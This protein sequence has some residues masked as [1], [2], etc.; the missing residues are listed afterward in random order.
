MRQ[1]ESI[2][3]KETYFDDDEDDDVLLMASQCAEDDDVLMM[4]SQCAEEEDRRRQLE[5]TVTEFNPPSSGTST[6][7]PVYIDKRKELPQIKESELSQNSQKENF[8][9]S[10]RDLMKKHNDMKELLAR[11]DRLTTTNKELRENLLL[12]EGEAKNL[13]LSK[14]AAEDKLTKMRHEKLESANLSRIDPEKD[15]L[16]REVAKLK[17]ERDFSKLDDFKQKISSTLQQPPV[18]IRE[19]SSPLSNTKFFTNFSM[20]SQSMPEVLPMMFEAEESLPVPPESL[21]DSLERDSTEDVVK[22]QLKLAQI[23]TRIIAGGKFSDALIDEIFTDAVFMIFRID[24][25]IKYLEIEEESLYTFDS[26]PA[27]SAAAAISIPELREKLTKV[28]LSNE[29]IFG[30]GGKI[31]IFQAE[32]FFPEE[33]CAKPRR[34]IAFYA[35]L[36]KNSRKFSEKLLIDNVVDDENHR[37]FVSVLTDTLLSRVSQSKNVYDYYGL[38]MAVG[39]L[40]SSLGSHYSKYSNNQIIDIALVKLLRAVLHCRCDNPILMVHVAQFVADT[41]LEPSIISQL[42]VNFPTSEITEISRTYR[43]FKY[44]HGACTFQLFLSYLLTTFKSKNNLNSFELELLME[45]LLNLNKIKSNVQEVSLGI[46][47]FLN[48][49]QANMCGCLQQL[50]NTTL[51]LNYHLLANQ[52]CAFMQSIPAREISNISTSIDEQKFHKR[53][54]SLKI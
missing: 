49:S 24:N 29:T 36:A 43:H 50:T 30:C 27:L 8:A 9:A 5:T 18:V 53:K 46:V 44:P 42:C 14:K 4:V 7:F 16:R 38:T 26:H 47:K 6:Q 23:H 19:V 25:F 31:S 12:K 54:L 39:S 11:I 33:L 22:S 41:S 20:N 32:K 2:I 13:R 17:T 34:I 10:Q 21:K 51:T 48:C 40:L 28:N 35:S 45:T 15:A 3:D 37:T 52:N 1:N